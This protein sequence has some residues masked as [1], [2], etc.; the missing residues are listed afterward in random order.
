MSQSTLYSASRTHDQG[1][2]DS[3][4]S[5]R[6]CP[7]CDRW[8][9]WGNHGTGYPGRARRGRRRRHR[10]FPYPSLSRGRPADADERNDRSLTYPPDRK[11]SL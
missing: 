4:L 3:L 2:Q 7:T 8:L 9:N 10:G 1:Q 5:G 11:E 6:P